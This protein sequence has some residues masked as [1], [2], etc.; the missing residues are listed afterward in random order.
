M[1]VQRGGVDGAVAVR[2]GQLSCM[3]GMWRLGRAAQAAPSPRPVASVIGSWAVQGLSAAVAVL[4]AGPC[5]GWAQ[6][7]MTEQ[8]KVAAGELCLC[9]GGPLLLPGALELQLGRA[10]AH[11]WPA[12]LRGCSRQVPAQQPPSGLPSSC[13]RAAP[14]STCS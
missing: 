8:H 1:Q 12:G 4:G 3:L 13:C 2:V 7:P 11:C 6:L 9:P 10:D 5:R 14:S